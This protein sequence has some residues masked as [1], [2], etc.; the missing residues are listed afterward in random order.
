MI[1]KSTGAR[2]IIA[3]PF[4]RYLKDDRF[5]FS[6]ANFLKAVR[7]Y[8]G[9][10][11][12]GIIFTDTHAVITAEQTKTDGAHRQAFIDL[13]SCINETALK[14]RQVRVH[15]VDDSNEK[16][17]MRIWLDSIGLTGMNYKKSRKLLMEPLTGICAYKTKA[18]LPLPVSVN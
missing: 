8:N 4:I 2:I 18:Q 1:E 11:M 17:S 3:E 6:T 7:N 13:I 15:R 5:T 9:A 14:N 16:F 12:M 10:S